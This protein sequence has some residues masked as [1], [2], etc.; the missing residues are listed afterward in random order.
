M[1]QGGEIFADEGGRT[2][3]DMAVEMTRSI[4]RQITDQ[5]ISGSRR[6]AVWIDGDGLFGEAGQMFV[7]MVIE[8][9]ELG[10]VAA[11][12][13][14]AA[15]NEVQRR[16][17]IHADLKTDEALAEMDQLI[18]AELRRATGEAAPTATN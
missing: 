14:A 8:R 3:E 4:S 2:V 9:E 12:I 13:R 18:E 1:S 16:A 17:Y 6:K 7:W 5:A 10:L 15:G 11:Q